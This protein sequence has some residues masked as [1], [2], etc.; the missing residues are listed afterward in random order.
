MLFALGALFFAP[1]R[2]GFIFGLWF[3]GNWVV[4]RPANY[5]KDK[6]PL[7]TPELMQPDKR[8]RELPPSQTAYVAATGRGSI[9]TAEIVK[10]SSVAEE[11]TRRL[12]NHSEPD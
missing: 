7:E 9:K 1:S 8:G 2:E 4:D 11:T 3:M 10:P 5:V 12:T 6:K